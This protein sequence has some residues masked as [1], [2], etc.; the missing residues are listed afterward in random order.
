MSWKGFAL[1][2]VALVLVAAPLRAEDERNEPAFKKYEKKVVKLADEIQDKVAAMRG[3]KFQAPV[4]KGVATEAELKKA[5]VDDFEKPENKKEAEKEEKVARAFGLIPKDFDLRHE[6][7]DLL[8]DQIAG[9]YDPE[10]KRLRLV[11]KTGGA[12]MTEQMQE[13]NDKMVMAHELE[14]ALQDQNFDLK[15]WEA[16]LEGHT[17]RTQAFRCV[18]EG[19]A[20]IVGFKFMFEEMGMAAPDMKTIWNM[21]KQAA[22]MDP[23]AA[24]AKEKMDKL[25]AY[26]T[27]NLLMAY[28][29]GSIFVEAV[30]DKGGWEAVSKLFQDPPASTAQILHPKKYFDKVEPR[31]IAMP[32]ISKLLKGTEIDQSTMGE[33]N[34]RL[35]LEGRGCKKKQARTIASSWAGDRYQ[36]FTAADGKTICLVWLTT[37]EDEAGAAA[38]HDA[39]KAGLEKAGE[40]NTLERRATEVLL[41]QCSDKTLRDKVTPKAWLSAFSTEHVKP[42]PSMLEK[43]PVK[44]FTEAD[45]NSGL[46]VADPG[47]GT[48]GA[49][50]GAAALGEAFRDDELGFTFRLPAGWKS[51]KDPI[52]R[53]KDFSR[54]YFKGKTSAEIRAL[55]LPMPWDKE[56]LTTQFQ[57]L[58]KQAAKDFKKGNERE[59]TVGGH[60]AY[61]VE[62]EGV[63]PNST[64]TREARAIAVERDSMTLVIIVSA[65]KGEL[66]EAI[67]GFEAM[68]GSFRFVPARLPKETTFTAKSGASLSTSS[69][70]SVKDE[71]KKGWLLATKDGGATTRLLLGTKP[72]ANDIERDL[73]EAE[74]LRADSLKGYKSLGTATFSH[75]A[76]GMVYTSDYELEVE[77]VAKRV[78]EL[79][80]LV[81]GKR[82]VL[83]C[84]CAPEAFERW[85]PAFERAVWT[86][87]LTGGGKATEPTKPVEPTKPTE[88][89]KAEPKKPDADEPF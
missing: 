21:N 89:K 48:A 26:L 37:W 54:G 88:P 63:M 84:T 1:S 70:F 10:A 13:I 23:A 76:L 29:D 24:K 53:V 9:F 44:D 85:K 6:M 3:L 42:F 51:D 8:A 45:P 2:L 80:A 14:H 61:E 86:L 30:F 25:P 71:D 16:I 60:E 59:L 47:K 35:V 58:L 52:E 12:E 78:H 46:G 36:V 22:G 72:F 4:P 67:P 68:L 41:V 55:D 11:R 33:A 32:S 49:A 79:A 77:G 38:F 17:D 69:D 50:A 39:M 20:T 81:D 28:E 7:R 40:A 15:R 73:K 83:T 27:R 31:E 18:F 65:K 74:K 34:M 57:Q 5:L 87:K 62:F 66:K 56:S 75:E 64:D 82:V 19:E 43:P